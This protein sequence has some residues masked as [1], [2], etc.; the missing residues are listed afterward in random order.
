MLNQRVHVV[1][2]TAYRDDVINCGCCY[3]TQFVLL[4]K[5]ICI[6]T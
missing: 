2:T 5:T 6:V 1:A 3:I 4:H